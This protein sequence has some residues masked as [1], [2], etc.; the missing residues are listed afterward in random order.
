MK[1]IFFLFAAVMS[2]LAVSCRDVLLEKNT[3]GF[4]VSFQT[5]GSS[6]RAGT[7]AMWKLDAWLELE[8]GAQLQKKD[9]TVLANAPITITF[10]AVPIGT[11]LKVQVRLEDSE[12][13]L[14]QH[15][16]SSDWITVDAE[17]K[18]VEV[19]VQRKSVNAAAPSIATQPKPLTKDYKAGDEV[20]WKVTLTVAADSPDGGN[21]I[22]QWFENTANSNSGG[23]LIP[24]ATKEDYQ[25]TLTPG[26]T[27]YFYCVVTNTNDAV[28]GTKDATTTSSVA[29]LVYNIAQSGVLLWNYDNTSTSSNNYKIVPS[30]AYNG[31]GVS[32]NES[33][34]SLAWCFDNTGN[35][36]WYAEGEN[37][38]QC[39]NLQSDKSY[40]TSGVYYSSPPFS[41]L[42]YDNS[43]NILYG[44]GDG[45]ALKYWQ[46][47]GGDSY[48]IL[49]D[50]GTGQ[51]SISDSLGFTVHNNIVYCATY[52]EKQEGDGPILGVVQLSS[53]KL[54]DA[55][56]G[57]SKTATSLRVDKT[58][59]LPE[60]FGSN[61]PTGQM[62]YQD[63]ALYL[64]LG[65]FSVSSSTTYS[66]TEVQSCGALLRINPSTLTLDTSF[67]NNGYLGLVSGRT[68]SGNYNGNDYFMDL[69]SPTESNENS[70]LESNEN[71]AFYGPVGF[72]A[73]MPKKLVI[74]D[75]GY[76]LSKGSDDKL[77]ARRKNRVVTVN[78]ET[79]AFDVVSLSDTT[80]YGN[81]TTGSGFLDVE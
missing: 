20:S 39:Y 21:L 41:A 51:F 77:S 27:K 4:S 56:D 73:V 63:G 71:S 15:E 68:I 75:A 29:K 49:L 23:T 10:D 30:G 81:I 40:S 6:S 54:K 64:L 37:G 79:Q 72:V 26:E 38:A 45:G 36:Y 1:K 52:A 8:S 59:T 76:A 18:T 9:D 5:P 16:G 3:G 65:S 14:I 19:Q 61:P 48:E 70:A 58:F 28:N 2:L 22:Y 7:T 67:G 47:T 32:L 11:K 33:S 69:Y 50:G 25:V 60:V 13:S 17:S 44:I 62:I 12:N 74:A 57:G 43:A 66:D 34:S 31:T 24:E 53:Y 55:S 78:L 80:F 42:S 46:K 35:L